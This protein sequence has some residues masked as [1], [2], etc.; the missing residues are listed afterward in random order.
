MSCRGGEHTI[1]R[2]SRTIKGILNI[3]E[4]QRPPPWK[5]RAI[6][7]KPKLFRFFRFLPQAERGRSP[8]RKRKGG[9]ATGLYQKQKL[10]GIGKENSV[11]L[12]YG[13]TAFVCFF[14]Y[15]ASGMLKEQKTALIPIAF[16]LLFAVIILRHALKS[17]QKRQ[18]APQNT[19]VSQK[20][21]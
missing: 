17:G 15:L 3:Q 12:A 9:K 2:R 5:M 13:I 21:N 16:S 19:S 8:R 4:K 11:R 14:A 6:S 18:G 1:C 20:R 7:Q 10:W